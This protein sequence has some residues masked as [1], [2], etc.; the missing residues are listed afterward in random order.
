[1]KEITQVTSHKATHMPRMAA[2]KSRVYG[3]MFQTG[4]DCRRDLRPCLSCNVHVGV[5]GQHVGALQKM[6]S[7]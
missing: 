5:L 4:R 6:L 2:S 7:S 3:S 1:M